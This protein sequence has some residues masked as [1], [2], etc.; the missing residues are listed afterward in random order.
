M[1]SKDVTTWSIL[2]MAVMVPA[3][4]LSA[5][6]FA[7]AQEE[8]LPNDVVLQETKTSTQGMNEGHQIVMALP[9]R[10]DSLVWMGYVTWVASKPVE[11]AILHGY[12]SSAVSNQT[13][14]QFGEPLKQT[15]GDIEVAMTLVKP[16]SG[17]SYPSGSIPFVGNALAFHTAGAVGGEPFT[18]TY[19]VAASA[20]ELTGPDTGEGEGN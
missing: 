2:A 3:I 8:E 1:I 20:E 6:S 13:S 12:N 10:G 9:P 19:T 18:V 7:S 15:F 4:F 14:A 11:V 16:E 17:T 5:S